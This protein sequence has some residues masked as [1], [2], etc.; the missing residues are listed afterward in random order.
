MIHR[1]LNSKGWTLTSGFS[2]PNEAGGQQP[3]AGEEQSVC[4]VPNGGRKANRQ[5]KCERE[6]PVSVWAKC[7]PRFSAFTFLAKQLNF[8]PGL[9]ECAT[10]ELINHK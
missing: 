5:Q 3:F 10:Q 6:S 8:I 1:G 9:K 2:F 4:A 7:L